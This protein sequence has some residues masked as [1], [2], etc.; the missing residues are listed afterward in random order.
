MQ[1]CDKCKKELSKDMKKHEV[2][3]RGYVFDLCSDCIERAMDWL[4]TPKKTGLGMFSLK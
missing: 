4:K 2:K 3:I 1:V